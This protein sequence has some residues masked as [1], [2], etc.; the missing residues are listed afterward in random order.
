MPTQKRPTAAQGKA[1][2]TLAEMGE[3]AEIRY[4]M[5]VRL[6]GQGWAVK[7]PHGTLLL[8]DRGRSALRLWKGIE[9][10]GQCALLAD[11]VE[12]LAAAFMEHHL[13]EPALDET[14]R[15][16]LSRYLNPT[17]GS[18]YLGQETADALKEEWET[19]LNRERNREAGHRRRLPTEAQMSALARI[20]QWPNLRIAGVES[21]M[22]RSLERK[23][24]L[25]RSSGW[26]LTAR[27]H[28][29]LELARE[30]REPLVPSETDVA[31]LQ[32]VK[33]GIQVSPTPN[34]IMEPSLVAGWIERRNGAWNLTEKGCKA[35]QALEG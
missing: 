16:A 2:A 25:D 3:Y 12:A 34:P 31:I 15:V 14:S 35:L 17:F 6:V 19:V 20:E 4:P 28:D 24:W 5:Q 22:V 10:P 23:G 9:G 26:R 21:T 33:Q 32:M 27:G 7:T 13:L 30:A 8:T 11:R 18:D 29:A 1:L